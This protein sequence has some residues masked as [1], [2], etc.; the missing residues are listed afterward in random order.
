MKLVDYENEGTID[1]EKLKPVFDVVA[2]NT[3]VE[4]AMS[5]ELADTETLTRDFIHTLAANP[6]QGV[7]E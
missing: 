7:V 4:G 3:E 5:L 2:K 1:A 6:R